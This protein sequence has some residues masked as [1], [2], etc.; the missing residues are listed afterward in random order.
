MRNN[1]PRAK[2]IRRWIKSREE[3]KHHY[4]VRDIPTPRLNLRLRIGTNIQKL[5]DLCTMKG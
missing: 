5:I 4:S 3:L 2:S 1:T